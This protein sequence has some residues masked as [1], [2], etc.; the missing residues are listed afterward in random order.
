M[1]L[2]STET[3]QPFYQGLSSEYDP[4][5]PELIADL[6]EALGLPAV[7]DPS[8]PAEAWSEALREVQTLMRAARRPCIVGSTRRCH[9]N[10]ELATYHFSAA[11]PL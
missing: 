10:E 11:S 3:V 6:R 8:A 2:E 7:F 9:C 5:L 1:A 4:S